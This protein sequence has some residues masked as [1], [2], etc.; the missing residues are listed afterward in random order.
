MFVKY[1]VNFIIRKRVFEI[2]DIESIEY[3]PVVDSWIHP[4][5]KII[6]RDGGRKKFTMSY[7]E[8]ISLIEKLETYGIKTD[9]IEY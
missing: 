2:I 8:L 5:F 7:R 1:P 9:K 6:S 3:K 4:Y